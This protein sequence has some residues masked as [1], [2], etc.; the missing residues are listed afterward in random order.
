MNGDEYKC[1]H[2]RKLNIRNHILTNLEGRVYT[3]LHPQYLDKIPDH[4]A[5]IPLSQPRHCNS[6]V[7]MY[8]TFRLRSEKKR[9][10]NIFN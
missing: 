1:I 7:Y 3:G 8:Y 5:N 2:L 9:N 4:K 10:K 6:L